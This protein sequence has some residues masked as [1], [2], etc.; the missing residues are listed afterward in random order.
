MDFV[1][2]YGKELFSALVAL[3]VWALNYFIKSRAKLLLAQPH[4]FTYLVNEPLRDTEGKQLRD[5]QLVHTRLFWVQNAGRETATKV[6]LVFNFKPMCTNI[7]PVRSYQ[8]S[9][10]ND[11]R[12]VFTFDSL[13]PN[14]IIGC[15]VLN[16][17]ND[18]PVLLYVRC[19]Q[20]AAKNIEMR[21]QPIASATRIRIA[22]IL[23]AFGLAAIVYL[24]ILVLQFLILKTPYGH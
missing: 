7:W 10:L 1:H 6:E 9:I 19:D 16:V 24:A 5:K 22:I 20:G 14:E 18:P 17:N 13:A 11:D 2:N 23:M 21:P 8:E 3:V 15:N 4:A 12:C